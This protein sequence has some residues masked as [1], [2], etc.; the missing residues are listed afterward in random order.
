MI[1]TSKMLSVGGH[2]HLEDPNIDM[3]WEEDR[4][5]SRSAR[6]PFVGRVVRHRHSQHVSLLNH[7]DGSVVW[8]WERL[9]WV[10]LE[11]RSEERNR[12]M[13]PGRRVHRLHSLAEPPLE[14]L[15]ES[16]ER[17]KVRIGFLRG[18]KRPREQMKAHLSRRDVG[19][20]DLVRESFF[21]HRP[22]VLLHLLVDSQLLVPSYSSR[23]NLD[24]DH[25]FAVELR[26][27]SRSQHLLQDLSLPAVKTVAES[28]ATV[29]VDGDLLRVDDGESSVEGFEESWSVVDEMKRRWCEGRGAAVARRR[30]KVSSLAND[31]RAGELSGTNWKR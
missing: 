27:P 24:S 23:N 30:R 1:L 21:N 10:G 11:R 14:V 7:V 9:T 31:K 28:D 13:E 19:S 29:D 3:S 17:W 18:S 15:R 16:R 4:R 8:R 2:S 12:R 22:D 26:D 5:R 20:D 25:G 6:V